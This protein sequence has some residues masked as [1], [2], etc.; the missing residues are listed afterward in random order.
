MKNT[1]KRA[2]AAV[3]FAPFKQG[4]TISSVDS[5]DIDHHK[6]GEMVIRVSSPLEP[7]PVEFIITVKEGKT[8]KYNV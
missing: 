4:V 8:L 7:T 6:D 5:Y 3:A 1:L 2:I